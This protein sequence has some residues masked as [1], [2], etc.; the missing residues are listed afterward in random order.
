MIS[1][2]EAKEL[3]WAHTKVQ[4]AA[5]MNLYDATGLVLAEDIFSTIDMPSFHQSAMDGYGVRFEDL[6]ANKHI[7]IIGEIPAGKSATYELKANTAV[8]IFTG[9]QIPF[10]CDT[11]IMQEKALVENGYLLVNDPLAVKGLNIRLQGSQIKKGILAMKA[12]SIIS[13]GAAGYLA[14][15]GL[16]SVK[17]FCKPKVCIINTGKELIKAGSELTDGMVYES[18]SY[19]LNGVL[20]EMHFTAE[21]ILMVD[22]DEALITEAITQKLNTCDVIILS[23]GVSVGDYDFV[24]K[25]IG[26]CGVQ[27]VFHRVKQKPGKPIYFGVLNNKLVFGLPGNP[28]A[29]L[30]CFYEYIAPSLKRMMGIELQNT[31]LKL[32]L[33]LGYQKKPGLTFLLKGI[34]SI[35]SVIPLPAQE[36]YLMSSF[37]KANCIIV[38][39]EETTD[40]NAGDLVEVHLLNGGYG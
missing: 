39:E 7:Q 26:N 2:K 34:A 38:L 29:A 37:S 31:A 10:G 9:A 24:A 21:D 6:M 32:P 23:G 12:G 28:G 22:D 25:A 8:R 27:E 16:N 1:V 17:V 19:S 18:N 30:T 20:V 11:V 33:T 15:L 13:P 40:Y 35:N 14:A 3:V 4:D 5:W 36:S